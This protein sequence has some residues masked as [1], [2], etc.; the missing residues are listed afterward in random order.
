MISRRSFCQAAALSVPILSRPASAQQRIA[1]QNSPT[2]WSYTS[3]KQYRDPFNEVELDVIFSA[4]SGEEHRIPAF[5]AGGSVWRVRYAPAETGRYKYRTLSSDTANGDLHGR[6][7]T[8]E[9]QPY[10]GDNSLYRHGFLR[11]SNDERHFEHAD[12]TPFFW[13]GDTWWMALSS[14][15]RWPDDFQTLTADRKKKGFTVVQIVA[16][17][18]PD[19][20]S[21]DP[22][23]A[24]EAGFPWER[25]Y[26]RINPAYFDMADVRIQYLFDQGI[27]PCIVGCW[28]YFLPLMGVKKIKQ[29]WRYLIARWGAYP[30]I[31]CLAGEATMPFYL[32][33]TPKEDKETQKHGWTDVARYVRTVGMRHPITLHPS[34]SARECVDD[35]SVMDF[36]MLQTGHDDRRSVPNTITT[37]NKSLEA[38]PKMPA[39]VGEVCYE[40]IQEASREEVQ[41]FMFWSC[42]L[43]GAAGHTY[44]A[45]GIW[46]VNAPGKPYGLSPHGHS[47]GGPSWNI[48]AQL[49]GSG[50]LGLGKALL[51]RFSWWR[52]KPRPELVQPHWTTE[53]YWQPFAAEIPG[54]GVIAYT[55]TAWKPLRFT[56]VEPGRYRAFLMNPSDGVEVL[57]SD[58]AVPDASGNWV[59]PEFPILRDWVV[60]L[61]RKTS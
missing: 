3:A 59:G 26:T 5:W 1:V 41:R 19:M 25:D 53:N 34:R 49:P 36:D 55:P 32:S 23:G 52:L 57:I 4:P 27:T 60:V 58:S 8:L 31:W 16:G 11:V 45:N 46:Q 17:L 14:R 24:N 13:L 33:K 20:P 28:G 30:A 50:Q 2:E 61:Q 48:A 10:T 12:G 43:S 47:W 38:A 35:P 51:T 56:G 40:G 18:Y 15:L 44:G 39:L 9:V 37:L 42:M 7:G 29:H 6:T 54:E 22:R 21:F